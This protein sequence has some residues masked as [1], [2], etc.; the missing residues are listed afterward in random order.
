MFFDARVFDCSICFVVS[1]CAARLISAQSGCLRILLLEEAIAEAVARLVW[2]PIGS[3]VSQ[4][5]AG[6][7]RA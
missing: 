6:H 4:M 7:F 5:H 3:F 2:V 1:L